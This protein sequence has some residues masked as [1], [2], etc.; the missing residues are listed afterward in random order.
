LS[1]RGPL[2][3]GGLAHQRGEEAGEIELEGE[4]IGGQRPEIVELRAR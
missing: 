1:K 2:E 3:L 4:R